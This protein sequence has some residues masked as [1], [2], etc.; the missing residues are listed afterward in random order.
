MLL[1]LSLCS[2]S[3]PHVLCR[4]NNRQAEIKELTAK[5]VLPYD[6]DISKH[7]ENSLKARTFLIGRVSALIHDVL[8]AKTIVDSMV[9]DAAQ[10]LTE[11]AQKI[12]VR[13]RL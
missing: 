1:A 10:I 9:D 3:V 13:A 5:G 4:N 2:A 6:D 11:N 8:P 7:P 12:K